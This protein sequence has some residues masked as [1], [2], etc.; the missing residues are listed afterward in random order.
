[1][2]KRIHLLTKKNNKKSELDR[3]LSLIKA[4]IEAILR[5]QNK[6]S[7]NDYLELVDLNP[8][9]FVFRPGDDLRSAAARY[10]KD[11]KDFVRGH[12][13]YI[14]CKIKEEQAKAK[15]PKTSNKLEALKNK[16]E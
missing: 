9:T 16:Y 2:L 1:M 14:S 3:T 4:K 11:L 5:Q 13:E 12:N 7:E 6:R 8:N 10:P 15:I